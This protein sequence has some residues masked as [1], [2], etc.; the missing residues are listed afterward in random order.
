MPAKIPATEAGAAAGTL[1]GNRGGCGGEEEDGREKGASAPLEALR[2][3]PLVVGDDRFAFAHSII[4]EKARGGSRRVKFICS[5][6]SFTFFF[7]SRVSSHFASCFQ[8]EEAVEAVL[9]RIISAR[10]LSSAWEFVTPGSTTD[11]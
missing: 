11:R 4:I 10:R 5:A 9:S 6:S 7:L 1:C 8:V 3:L 2:A